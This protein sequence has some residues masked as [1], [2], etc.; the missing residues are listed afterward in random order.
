MNGKLRK[1]INVKNM[2]RR[3]FYKYRTSAN[4]EPYRKHRNHVVQLR[5]TCAKEYLRQHTVKGNGDKDFW[6]SIKP[7]M[8]NKSANKSNNVILREGDSIINDPMDVSNILNEYYV[9]FTRSIGCEDAIS[10]GESFDDIV[11]KHISN[12]SI[13]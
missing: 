6:K 1:A 11:N 5:K 10:D 8:S 13:L 9:N 12:D 7:L 2:Y 3:K 4:W